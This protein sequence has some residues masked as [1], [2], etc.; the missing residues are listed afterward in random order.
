MRVG[1][2]D[3]RLDANPAGRAGGRLGVLGGVSPG[4]GA[5]G[6]KDGP[7]GVGPMPVLSEPLGSSIS[8]TVA[9]ESFPADPWAC[10]LLLGVT[11]WAQ[12]QERTCTFTP[13]LCVRLQH[14]CHDQSA[15]AP[16]LPRDSGCPQ[17]RSSAP[18]AVH[19]FAIGRTISL[20]VRN[21]PI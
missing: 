20:R 10:P 17:E 8:I 18:P 1:A 12:L 9:Q 14:V 21:L 15:F 5:Q 7:L 3:L 2:L 6:M 13:S 4:P 16:A 19:R 11:V